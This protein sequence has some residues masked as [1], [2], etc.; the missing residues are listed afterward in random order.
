MRYKYRIHNCIAVSEVLGGVLL[1]LIAVL[2]FTAIY[3]FVFPLPE[4]TAEPH[5]KLIGYVT[6]EGTAIIE[7]V[8]G[9]TLSSYQVDVRA[10]NGTLLDS[11]TYTEDPWGIGEKIIPSSVNLPT[12]NDSIE[13]DVF[14]FDREGNKISVFEGILKGTLK[15]SSDDESENLHYPWLISSLLTD[16][17]DEDLICFNKTEL[18]EELNSSFEASSYVYNWF[19]NDNPLTVLNLPLDV[20]SSIEIKDYSGLNHHAD[21][22]DAVWDSSGRIGGGYYLDGNSSIQIPYCFSNPTIDEITVEAWIKTSNPNGAIISYNR[23]LYFE[24]SIANGNVLWDGTT[25]TQT[26]KTNSPTEVTD[27]N[28][29]LIT[30]TYDRSSGEAFIFIDGI[31]DSTITS[32]SP[33]ESLGLGSQPFGYIGRSRSP[34][35]TDYVS[36][37]TDDFE[38]DKGW[39]VD[40]SYGLYDGSWERGIPVDDDR[41]DPPEDS[42]GSGNCYVTE[43]EREKDID[44]GT[45]WLVSPIFD[46]SDYQ[47]VNCTFDVWYTNNHG[48]SANNDYFYVEVSDDDGGSWTT[49]LTIG[50]DTPTPEQWY[51]YTIVLDDYITLTDNVKIRFEASDLGYGSVV[52][53]GVD[54]FLLTGLSQVS[55]VNYT[56]LIDEVKIYDRVLSEEQIYQNYLSNYNGNSSISVIVSEETIVGETWKC[57]VTP[58]NQFVDACTLTSNELFIEIYEGGGI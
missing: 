27:D 7:H 34:P 32:T 17:T 24:L 48:S 52:E 13:V 57:E 4:S 56:G 31:I 12:D 39:T 45:T 33:G 47:T 18:G 46:L 9:E 42:D 40:D 55:N 30:A 11:N 37:F 58:T 38:T 35:P 8:G 50:P 15:E 16:T 25:S 21:N 20:S 2:S 10:K 3:S 5:V 1:L 43:N 29:H 54:D 23:S 22:H 53:A 44:G 26:M 41:G 28:W 49:A 36:I 19:L 14:T 6:Q 51:S